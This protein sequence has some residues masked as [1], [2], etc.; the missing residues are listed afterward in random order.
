[1]F[2]RPVLPVLWLVTA[3][4]SRGF[5]QT[6]DDE[7]GDP[8]VAERYVQWAEQAIQ[9]GHW[10]EA[11]AALERAADFADVSSDISYLLALARSRQG[12][13]RGAVLEAARRALEADRWRRYDPEAAR[14]LEAETLIAL[15]AFPQA[16]RSL[17]AVPESADAAV[18]RL[19]ALLGLPDIPAFRGAMSL[20]L[21]RYP[22]DPRPVRV[23]FTYG[24]EKLPRGNERDLVSLALRRLPLLLEAEPELAY[25]AVPFIRDTGKARRLVAAYRAGGLVSSFRPASPAA[26]SL[27]VALGLGLIGEEEATAEFFSP[28]GGSPALD[29]AL[30]RTLWGLLR[31]DAARDG[32][33]R[34]LLGFSGVIVEDRDKDGYIEERTRYRDG[35]ITAYS[36]DADQDGLPETEIT[37]IAGLP[38]RGEVVVLPESSPGTFVYPVDDGDRLKAR[39][40]WERYP[41]V[42]EVEL[43]GIRYIPRPL[44]FS[45]APVRLGD[46]LGGEGG[47]PCP[48]GDPHTP[49]LSQR[50]LV[51]F[52]L[53]LERPGRDGAVEQVEL[54]RGVPRRAR[55][56]LDGRLVS[57][58][59]FLLGR[60]VLQTVDLDLDGRMETRRRFPPDVKAFTQEDLRAPLDLVKI[61]E[62][63]ESDW[64]G[65]GIFEYREGYTKTEDN[66]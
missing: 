40:S 55:E 11:A 36:H 8:A 66:L 25:L 37:F 56:Y 9:G 28:P 43:D 63:S 26:A 4:V 13:P 39:V 54:D 30:L 60:P 35:M 50:S 16:L 38:F 62:S 57:V 27:P 59:D 47:L 10:A 24:A 12:R 20:A 6:G 7:A 2:R 22:R 41:A 53:L 33:R 31:T 5:P 61:M 44:E 42:L 58:T 15:R 52:A 3:I 49:R 29:K 21:E 14:L 23:L 19:R 18:L 64:D 48:E 34:N 1:V 45:F 65:D 51:S 46:L 32:F 17:A